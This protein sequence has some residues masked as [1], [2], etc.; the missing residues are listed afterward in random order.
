VR[1]PFNF[2]EVSLGVGQTWEV[3][4]IEFPVSEALDE[5][6]NLAGPNDGV[7]PKDCAPSAV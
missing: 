2:F 1:F 3:V 7:L 6:T 4:A 5:E